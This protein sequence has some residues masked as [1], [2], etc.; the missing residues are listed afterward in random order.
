[1]VQYWTVN[2]QEISFQ[3]F[4]VFIDFDDVGRLM[5]CTPPSQ[6]AVRNILPIYIYIVFPSR[7]RALKSPC[8]RFPPS[9]L[10]W[11]A[12]HAQHEPSLKAAAVLGCRN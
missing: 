8:W 6:Y 5:S 10:F 11:L 4:Y 1:M 2:S 7:G 3:R 12:E 9:V